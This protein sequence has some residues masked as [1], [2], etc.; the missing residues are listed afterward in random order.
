MLGPSIR[1]FSPM[2]QIEGRQRLLGR[3]VAESQKSASYRVE[4]LGHRTECNLQ[5]LHALIHGGQYWPRPVLRAY[6]HLESRW[7]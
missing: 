1:W 7:K 2:V 6:I 3:A 4:H 5:R